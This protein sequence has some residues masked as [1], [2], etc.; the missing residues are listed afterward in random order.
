VNGMC[1]VPLSP[2]GDLGSVYCDDFEGPV[3]EFMYLR[4]WSLSSS[5]F[6]VLSISPN[7]N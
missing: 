6:C 1:T 4:N 3:Y 2:L 5:S 7:D